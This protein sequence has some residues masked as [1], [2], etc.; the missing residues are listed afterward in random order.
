MEP[1]PGE[2]GMFFRLDERALTHA[3]SKRAAANRLGLTVQWGAVRMLGAFVTEDLAGVPE[4]VVRFAAD[5]VRR[6]GGVRGVC[7]AAAEPV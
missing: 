1:S 6:S 3:R 5:Q 2:L 7:G 4:A